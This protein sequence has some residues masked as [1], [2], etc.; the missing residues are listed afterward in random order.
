MRKCIR[1]MLLVMAAAVLLAGI[2]P[3]AASAHS[4]RHGLCRQ[5]AVRYASRYQKDSDC[6]DTPCYQEDD[7]CTEAPCYQEN[8]CS[9]DTPCYQEDDCGGS[10]HTEHHSGRRSGHHSGRGHSYHH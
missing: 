4:G 8:D 1:K 5:M 3:D 7:Y 10:R 9:A 6:T 2:V